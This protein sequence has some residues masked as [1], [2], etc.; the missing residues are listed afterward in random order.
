MRSF[1]YQLPLP[2]ST[3]Y[4]IPSYP[5]WLSIHHR[6]HSHFQA[7]LISFWLKLPSFPL[8]SLWVAP[9][10]VWFHPLFAPTLCKWSSFPALLQKTAEELHCSHGN[11]L[12][13]HP[14]VLCAW[15]TQPGA[16]HQ[17]HQIV[18]SRRQAWPGQL[19]KQFLGESKTA[20]WKVMLWGGSKLQVIC[21]HGFYCFF[22]L[23]CFVPQQ[24]MSVVQQFLENC[25]SWIGVLSL[26]YKSCGLTAITLGNLRAMIVWLLQLWVAQSIQG[27][28]SAVRS[29]FCLYNSMK[30]LLMGRSA[31]HLC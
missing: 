14:L 22:F 28:Y 27:L 7:A 6:L 1:G 15:G 26:N 23:A 18:E 8:C 19:W 31:L 9:I 12:T 11:T 30:R 13:T 21:L 25:W 4:L 5:V 17:S 3:P 20:C 16:V 2:W 10:F 29:T 24:E